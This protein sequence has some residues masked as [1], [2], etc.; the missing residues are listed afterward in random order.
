VA[1]SG[2]LAGDGDDAT[3]AG[4]VDMVVQPEQ[5]IISARTAA[6]AF[7][8]PPVCSLLDREEHRYLADRQVLVERNVLREAQ[9][10]ST[11]TKVMPVL[12]RV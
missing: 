2:V 4:W 3:G 9:A 10:S 7:I 1:P 6:T 5:L 12:V 8:E 11:A